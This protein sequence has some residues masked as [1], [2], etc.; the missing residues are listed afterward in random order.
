MKH[1]ALSI[2]I[3]ALVAV[4]S[5]IAGMIIATSLHLSADSKAAPFWVEGD[6]A[7]SPKVVMPSLRNLAQEL[8]PTVV[9]IRTTKLVNQKDLYKRFRSPGGEEDPFEEFFNKFFNSMP[10]K[11]TE[12]KSLGSGFIVSPDGYIL[13]NEHVVSGAE[14]IMVSLTNKQEYDAKVIGKDDKTDIALIKIDTGGK[15]LPAAKLGNSDPL[16]IGDWV[17]AIGN[18]FGLGNTVTVGIV[19]AKARIIGAGPYDNFIQTDAAINPGNS[20]GPLIDMKGQ[21]IGIN[22]AIVAAGQGIGFAIPINM[23]KE[24]L[25]E[26]KAT[27]Q[28]TRGWLG[29]GIQEVS[30]EI[31]RAVGLKEVKGAM[32]TMVYPGDPADKA[33]VKKG[34]IILAVNGQS[35]KG[36]FDL[37]HL[38]A[39][40]KPGAKIAITVWREKRQVELSSKLEKRTDEHV[41]SLGGQPE[42]D[43]PKESKETKDSLGLTLKDITPDLAQRLKLEDAKGVVVTGIDPKGPASD[44]DIK[45]GDVI[46]EV[47]RHEITGTSDYLKALKGLSKGETVL[48]RVLR[49]GRPFYMAIDIP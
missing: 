21:V 36:P 42:E 40:L 45:K 31:A 47:N 12:Q 46:K 3:I 16:E 22:T 34:D 8:S 1:K 25:L 32:V 13:T 18:P 35:I 15:Q 7:A 19:S 11:E 20:G 49:D 33:G 37:T 14:K 48:L 17:M 41:A 44:S 6:P 26:L 9:N 5:A 24:I 27:G 2:G 30:P 39:T 43:Q 10:D 38:I 28:V 29:V 4:C 23:A